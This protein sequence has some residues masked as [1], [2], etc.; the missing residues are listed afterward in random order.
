MSFIVFSIVYF[1]L[2][3]DYYMNGEFWIFESMIFLWQIVYSI[4]RGGT[5]GVSMELVI[6]VVLSRIPL[7]DIMKTE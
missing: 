2:V 1:K 6:V 4:S 5:G 7:L 3:Y